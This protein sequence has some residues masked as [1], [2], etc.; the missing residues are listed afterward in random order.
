LFVCG[1]LR[2]LALAVLEKFFN[3]DVVFR[4]VWNTE[5]WM[6]VLVPVLRLL[7]EGDTELLLIPA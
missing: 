4:E 3:G 5:F 1:F 2:K 6:P 7:W